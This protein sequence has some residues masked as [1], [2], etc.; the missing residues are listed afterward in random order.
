MLGNNTGSKITSVRV[1]RSR[2]GVESQLE[3]AEMHP[4]TLWYRGRIGNHS[5]NLESAMKLPII[6]SI[7][8]FFIVLGT[9]AD[10][11]SQCSSYS[12]SMSQEQLLT[13][14]RDSKNTPPQ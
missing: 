1:R 3:L 4:A 8:F 12:Q 14:L 13:I 7:L 9:V 10:L 5:N 6:H 11:L 2:I